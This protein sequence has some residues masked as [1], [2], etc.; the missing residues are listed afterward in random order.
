MNINSK[1]KESYKNLIEYYRVNELLPSL[2]YYDNDLIE[3]CKDYL[4]SIKIVLD[5]INNDEVLSK[6]ERDLFKLGT[7]YKSRW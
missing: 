7:I 1:V 5:N 2:A 3:I 6:E 4:S